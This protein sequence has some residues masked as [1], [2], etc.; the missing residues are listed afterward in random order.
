MDIHSF[1]SLIGSIERHRSRQIIQNAW[2]TM[3]ASQGTQKSLRDALKPF[4][5]SAGIKGPKTMKNA[6]DFMKDHGPVI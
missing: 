5:R 4:E 3:A 2:L 1:D 6:K